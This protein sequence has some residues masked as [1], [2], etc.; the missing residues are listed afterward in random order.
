MADSKEKKKLTLNLS[1]D[2]HKRLKIAAAEEDRTITDIIEELVKAFLA[3]R[4]ERR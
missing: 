2:L 3:N 4:L 1:P